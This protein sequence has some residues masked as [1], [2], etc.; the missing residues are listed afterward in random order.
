MAPLWIQ[1]APFGYQGR[2]MESYDICPSQWADF[3]Q[4]G[5][6]SLLFMGEETIHMESKLEVLIALKLSEKTNILP[7][8]TPLLPKIRLTD[9]Q[10]PLDFLTCPLDSVLAT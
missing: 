10:I 7:L 3:C 9:G 2:V 4:Y 1:N 6:R 5:D 8:L